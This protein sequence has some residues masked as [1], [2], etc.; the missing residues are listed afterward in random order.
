MAKRARVKLD[1]EGG[2]TAFL[3]GPEVA[4][5]VRSSGDR[6]A[7]RAGDGFEA[8]TWVSPVRGRRLPARVISGV[9]PQTNKARA[10]QSRDNV[11]LR[12]IDAGRV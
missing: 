1:T 5:M 12:S 11:L 9:T 3:R 8:D 7:A 4:R 6:V 10:R 2:M